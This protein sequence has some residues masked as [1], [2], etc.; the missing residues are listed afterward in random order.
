M[1]KE[2]LKFVSIKENKSIFSMNQVFSPT[3]KQH[4]IKSKSLFAFSLAVPVSK[5]TQ[6]YFWLKKKKVLRPLPSSCCTK[7]NIP[8]T[9]SVWQYQDIA[10]HFT[11]LSSHIVDLLSDYLK[12]TSS[13]D[14]HWLKCWKSLRQVTDY[15]ITHCKICKKKKVSF[16]CCCFFLAQQF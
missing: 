10:R 1:K 4:S 16:C 15:L 6:C 8:H 2:N 3:L 7:V 13:S 9:L 5:K 11:S 12:S 14:R